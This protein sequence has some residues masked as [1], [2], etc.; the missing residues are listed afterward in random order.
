[1]LDGMADAFIRDSTA[2]LRRLDLLVDEDLE[3]T[4]A[5]SEGSVLKEKKVGITKRLTGISKYDKR[6]APTG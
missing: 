5:V 6:K 4:L 3:C 1:M 2:Q